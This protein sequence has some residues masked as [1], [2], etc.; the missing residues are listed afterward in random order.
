MKKTSCKRGVTQ[1][2]KVILSL[3]QDLRRL[4]LP[5]VNSMRG[6]S[7]I[8]YGMTSLFNHGGFTLI[9]LLV[10]VLIIGILAAVAVPQYQKAVIKS[11]VV[12][13]LVVFNAYRKAIDVWLSENGYPLESV[14]FTGGASTC[15]EINKYSSLDI[16]IEGEVV[17]C[18]N[19][20]GKIYV[21]AK[22]GTSN[23]LIRTPKKGNLCY[24]Q[25]QRQ[26]GSNE[27]N[28]SSIKLYSDESNASAEDCTDYQRIMCQYWST[29]G[30]GLGRNPSI[31]QCARF[32][33][34]LTLAE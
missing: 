30:T 25:F 27:W 23:A 34:S 16:N 31:T 7:R 26:K 20:V 13:E 9:E 19:K 12:Q 4:S 5:L 29:Q 14:R 2:I 28:L 11:G 18:Y 32:G 6:R 22:V 1:I 24:A 3:T 15:S 17:K 10:V 8:K 33:I 21:L